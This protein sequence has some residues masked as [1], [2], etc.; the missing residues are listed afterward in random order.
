VGG[1]H[2]DPNATDAQFK[3]AAWNSDGDVEVLKSYYKEW[4]PVIR[5]MVEATPYIRQY[6]NTYASSLDTWVHGNG[7]VTFVGD[8]AH[9]HGGA[10][11][12]GGSLAADDAYSFAM[13]MSHVFS[14]TSTDFSTERIREALHLHE[15]TRKAHTDRVLRAVHEGN[16]KTIKRLRKTETDEA[17]RERIQS[18]GDPYWIHE[19][20][21]EAAFEQAINT[22]N[23]DNRARL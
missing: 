16:Q 2:G 19:H 11:A 18:R 20:D 4:H 23:A 8:A 9:A 3:D 10:F 15:L 21:V 13:A 1:Y 5:R 17:L 22:Y 14:P 12:A 6:P 7:R